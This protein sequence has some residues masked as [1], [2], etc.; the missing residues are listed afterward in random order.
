MQ[1]SKTITDNLKKL[2]IGFA[3]LLIP[4][5]Y[6]CSGCNN[7]KDNGTTKDSSGMVSKKDS[8]NSMPI[9]MPPDSTIDTTKGGQTP[10]P[11]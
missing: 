3:F 1:L 5:V 10:P 6:G 4:A 8:A 2:F 7:N 9:V 11:H